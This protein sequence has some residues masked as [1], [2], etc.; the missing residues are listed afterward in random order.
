M[1]KEPDIESSIRAH[2]QY[3]C[4][5]IGARGSGGPQERQAHD[6]CSNILRTSGY[7]PIVD[8]FTTT[9]SAYRPFILA[10]ALLLLS[11]AAAYL[12]PWRLPAALIAVGVTTS[13]FL[14]L[15]FIDNPLRWLLPKYRSRNVHA[16]LPARQ[17]PRRQIVLA[18]HVD[19]HRT[20]WIWRSRRTYRLYRLLST[21]GMVAFPA[22]SLLIVLEAC[23]P[24]ATP[25]VLAGLPALVI[26]AVLAMTV[27]AELSPHTQGA[28][29]NASGA[30]LV[31]AL[32]E[33]AATAPLPDI[34]LRFLFTGCEE[35]GAHGM[36]AF[37]NKYRQS[38]R[39]AVVL[40]LDNI[41]GRETTPRY[42]TSETLL[43]LLRTPQALVSTAAAI[44][45]RLPACDARPFA[46]HGAYTDAAPALIAGIPAMAIVSHSADGWIP[47][48][49]QPSDTSDRVDW[50][51]LAKARSFIEQLVIVLAE[52]PPQAP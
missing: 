19:T 35:V 31:L 27:Q 51:A 4:T 15:A 13:A 20:P 1:K 37:V 7:S 8:E 40:V 18:A 36:A 25:A 48:W 23:R 26:A 9:A 30:A 3:F 28:N 10:T 16:V 44:A 47:D 6:Y 38:L 32:A 41:G 14:D 12:T 34:E 39:N 11:A 45:E 33:S 22:L 17:K 21:L 5:T 50:A 49:H 2:L 52:S 46:Q 43:R 42:Y 29:D 24:G